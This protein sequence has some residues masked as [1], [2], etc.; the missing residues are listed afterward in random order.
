MPVGPRALA[1]AAVGQLRARGGPRI[2]WGKTLASPG[3]IPD[4]DIRA[5]MRHLEEHQAT[6]E[7]V[8]LVCDWL[9]EGKG[10]YFRGGG[11]LERPGSVTIQELSRAFGE[12]L[13]AARAWHEGGRKTPDRRGA[14]RPER[15]SL[16]DPE[17]EAQLRELLGGSE[18]P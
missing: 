2:A 6:A 13:G 18:N 3:G 17:S 16:T 5:L 8:E 4:H 12:A 10:W 11:S 9:R 14:P 7:D 15:R 1:P